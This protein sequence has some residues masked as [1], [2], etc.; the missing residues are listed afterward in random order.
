MASAPHLILVDNSKVHKT[1]RQIGPETAMTPSS[2]A[3]SRRAKPSRS[4]P[5][6]VVFGPTGCHTVANSCCAL[7]ADLQT[8]REAAIEVD[9]RTKK[10]RCL[11]GV[12][13]PIHATDVI[14][15]AA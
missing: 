7:P 11:A 8:A 2:S 10:E 4:S 15:E 9:P 3:L 13:A 1:R 6:S 12:P 14:R 5:I